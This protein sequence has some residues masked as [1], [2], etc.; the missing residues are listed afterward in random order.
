MKKKKTKKKVVKKAKVKELTYDIY[1]H[2]KEV[3]TGGEAESDEEFSSHEPEYIDFTP[4]S[5]YHFL[6]SKDAYV[7]NLY[8]DN[9]DARHHEVKFD[10]TK[11]NEAFAVIVRYTTG[12]TFGSTHGAWDATKNVITK[13]ETEKNAKDIKNETGKYSPEKYC[14]WHGYFQS[15]ESVGIHKLDI[16]CH[17]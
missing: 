9:K 4:L 17:A 1:L 15:F 2:Y 12:D 8:Y 13:K 6:V 7:N 3:R 14:A 16:I 11:Y 5:L 10:P